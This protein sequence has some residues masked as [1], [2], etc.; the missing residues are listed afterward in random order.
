MLYLLLVL[1]VLVD[2]DYLYASEILNEDVDGLFFFYSCTDRL[3]LI[4][5][6][7]AQTRKRVLG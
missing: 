3:K 1:V 6:D 5:I 7:S 4:H 2:T